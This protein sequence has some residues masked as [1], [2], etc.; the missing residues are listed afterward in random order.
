MRLMGTEDTPSLTSLKCQLPLRGEQCL[1]GI[2]CNA[3]EIGV[4]TIRMRE[5]GN[6]DEIHGR[7]QTRQAAHL[8][9]L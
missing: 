2:S 1:R 5:L 6:K 9:L 8:T 4:E 3:V 7:S